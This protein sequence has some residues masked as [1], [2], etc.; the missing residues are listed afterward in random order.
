MKFRLHASSKTNFLSLGG[1][2]EGADGL[3]V[4]A[5]ETKDLGDLKA[6]PD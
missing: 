4:G 1:G 3:S 6:K 5:G 2:A